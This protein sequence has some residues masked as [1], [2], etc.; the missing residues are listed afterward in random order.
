[1]EKPVDFSELHID[2]APFQLVEKSSLL[3]VLALPL[4]CLLGPIFPLPAS[5]HPSPPGSQPVL[6]AR[7][8]PRLRH[9][10]RQADRCGGA[11][12]AQVGS[13]LVGGFYNLSQESYR[14]RQLWGS[15]RS[16]PGTSTTCYLLPA[17]T[18]VTTRPPSRG[19]R[20][21]RLGSDTG[22]LSLMAR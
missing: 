12:G 20:R 8:Q 16:G 18:A 5:Y 11:Q 2:P 15:G 1:M 19:T 21:A 4:A 7:C 9:H 17:T 22:G 10:H 6:H 14:G 3:K 13:R